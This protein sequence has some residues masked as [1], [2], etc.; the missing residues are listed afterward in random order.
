MK[1]GP[2]RVNLARSDKPK[3]DQEV[4]TAASASRPSLFKG[5]VIASD[6]VKRADYI[7]MRDNDGTAQA[8][9]S[10]LTMP[11]LS[12]PW[13]IEPANDSAP[14]KQQAEDVEQ[15]LKLP[16]HEGGMS[17]PMD[18]VLEDMLRAFIEG[19]R[20]FEKV[21]A[22]N[23]QGRFVFRKIASRDPETI[24]LLQDDRGGFAGAKQN[25]YI[26]EE[27]K[28]VTIPKEKC[29]LYTF[30]KAFNWLEGRSA[31]K[32]G[33]Y[34][35]D[36]KHRLYYA[37]H[38]AVD[39]GGLP[40]RIVKDKPNNT[41]E[42][43]DETVD[44]VDELG[45]RSTVGL[46][47]GYDLLPYEAGKGRVDP[48]PLI[49]H[50]NAEMARSILA[51]FIMLG[52]GSETGSWALS[53]DQSDMFVMALSSVARG[54]E[55]HI[56]SYL[57][58]DLVEF[59]YATP[60]YPRFKFADMEA[61][62][63]DTLRD[64][65]LKIFE[66]KPEG[67]PDYLVEA[68]A[69]KLADQLDIPVPSEQGKAGLKNKGSGKR[70]FLAK[71]WRRDLTPAEEKVNFSSIQK[72]IDT[73]EGD[74][75]SAAKPIFD[76]LRADTV[77]RVDKLLQAEDYKA[78]DSLELKFGN[79][80]KNIIT[81]Q[82]LDAYQF[83]KVGAADELEVKAPATKNTSKEVIKQQAQ[84]IVDKQFA[85]IVFAVREAVNAARRKNQLS[86]TELSIGDVLKTIGLAITAFYAD[87]I[88]P[89]ATASIVSSISMGRD[90]V[91]QAN[92][93]KISLYQYSAILD[94]RT[95]PICEDLDGTV[96]DEAEYRSTEWLPPIHF[97]CR[98]IWVAILAD[99]VEQ[100][101]ISGFPNEPGGILEPLLS[102]GLYSVMLNRSFKEN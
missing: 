16:P 84:A 14:A 76:K 31:F 98:C 30:G 40:P 73:L 9:Y 2:L 24:T 94:D 74:F 82:M 21:Y 101:E 11:L 55:S 96:V 37:A 63:R 6:T 89:T 4:G 83:A 48:V 69:E 29:F 36:K 77:A 88:I 93:S 70:P 3:P 68:L 41:Q 53:K 19:Y 43:L 62:T 35:Y 79:E 17:T 44:A 90:D 42:K 65:G 33:Y 97:G 46:P 39:F 99:E 20:L 67:I 49:D 47:H 10:I 87:K 34:H 66:K 102:K 18:L 92:Q 57:L 32:A 58:P 45:F 56:T 80:Y 23:E 52:T 8:L 12:M 22:I 95:C 7:K 61:S 59:N 91:F 25:A 75:V 100:P 71:R 26:G 64:I 85:D 86:N 1:I 13:S 38:Q 72:K 50:H 28:T 15:A 51:H 27:Y 54:V 81:D 5:E 78:L 60:L